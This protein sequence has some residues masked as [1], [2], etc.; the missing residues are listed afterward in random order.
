MVSK[1]IYVFL[2][3][4]AGLNA[5]SNNSGGTPPAA[6]NSQVQKNPKK[7]TGIDLDA[8]QTSAPQGA[9]SG[10][11]FD[12]ANGPSDASK[13]SALKTQI[14]TQIQYLEGQKETVIGNIQSLQGTRIQNLN[15][16]NPRA[17]SPT[18]QGAVAGAGLDF[19][20]AGAAAAVGSMTGGSGG[21]GGGSGNIYDPSNSDY[22][23]PGFAADGTFNPSGV[24]A[25]LNGVTAGVSSIGRG[26]SAAITTNDIKNRV[27]SIDGDIQSQIKQYQA[28]ADNLQRQIDQLNAQIDQL[29]IQGTN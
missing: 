19:A 25:G 23:R 10:G 11:L 21:G 15:L 14:Q 22:G 9:N 17:N 4:G 6:T 29:N 3:V 28:Q 27:G 5:C 8:A 20:A 7:P 24:L 18:W 1:H 2:L 13:R 26:V 12:L 16:S